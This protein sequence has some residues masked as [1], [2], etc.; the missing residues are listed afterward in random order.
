M[1]C[2]MQ[3]VTICTHCDVFI[4]LSFGCPMLFQPQLISRVLYLSEQKPSTFICSS[5]SYWLPPNFLPK[6]CDN[7]VRNLRVVLVSFP[8]LSQYLLVVVL[9]VPIGTEIHEDMFGH[10]THIDCAVFALTIYRSHKL[11]YHLW[12]ARSVSLAALRIL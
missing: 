7:L 6:K 3:H 4:C 9:M 11:L 1:H 12:N 2:P 8:R 10:S 5:A